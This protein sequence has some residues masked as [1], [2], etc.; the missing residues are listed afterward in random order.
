MSYKLKTS[1]ET[2]TIF[3][4]IQ[5]S[6]HLDPFILSKLAISMSIRSEQ[7]FEELDFASDNKGLELN[8]QQVTGE[9]DLIY[10]QLITV[11]HGHPLTDEEF[12]PK[13]VKAHLDRGAKYLLREFRYNS[14]KFMLNLAELDKGI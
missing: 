11:K 14:K 4:N 9:Y 3:K 2:A 10:K 6:Q 5:S 12:F 7:D 13:L 1:E 8:R